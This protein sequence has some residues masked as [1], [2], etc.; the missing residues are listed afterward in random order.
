MSP[1]RVGIVI[2]AFAGRANRTIRVVWLLELSVL[3]LAVTVA[4]WLRF[5]DDPASRGLFIDTAPVRSLLVA[6]FVTGA[7]AAFGL[8]QPHVRHNRIDLMLRIGLGFAFGGVGLLVLYY[9][10]PSTYIGRGVL[11]LSLLIGFVLIC[12]LRLL[13]YGLFG[14]EAFKRRILIL[15]AGSNADLINRRLRR[16][17]DRKAFTVVGFIPIDGQAQVVSQDLLVPLQGRTLRELALELHAHEIVV[18]PD[19]RRGGLPMDQI[20][21]C[22]QMGVAIVDLPAF[23]ERE[24]GLIKLEIADPSTLVFSGGFDHS[25]PRRLSKRA[26]DIAAALVLLLV[27]WPF[28]LVVALCVWAE[29]GSPILYRQTRVGEGG[30]TFDLT[31]FRSMRTDAEKD[32]VARWASTNDDRTTRVGRFIRAT[33]LDEL[34]QLFNVLAGDMSFVGPRPE[35]PQFVDQLNEEIRYYNVR[36]SVKPGLTGWA[37][38][39][40]PYGASVNDAR[41]KLKF[42]LFYVKNHGL[43]FDFMILLQTVEVVLFRRGAR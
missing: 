2:G 21:Q 32:G 1:A 39:R 5:I 19:E 22:A 36:H 38:L 16:R 6:V 15:G 14:M 4:V 7:M 10:L 25:F 12:F 11:A 30:R 42:D 23:F 40:Y 26:F 37:Q 34:P 29:S 41:E 35:R 28:M 8:Y 24:A 20:L 18:A 17:S 9:A 33:R 43:F 27:A 13:V 31:K 3:L